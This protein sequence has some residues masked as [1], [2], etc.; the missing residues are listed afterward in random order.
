VYDYLQFG[1]PVEDS[2]A[3]RALAQISR[4]GAGDQPRRTGPAHASPG[5]RQI[6]VQKGVT[7]VV[8]P[9]TDMLS[10]GGGV[11]QDFTHMMIGLA[12]AMKIPARY[13]SGL[14]HPD[15]QRYRAFQ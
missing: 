7:T 15:E 10:K 4:P 11:C 3:L 2:P 13:V 1:G 14:V 5:G 12:R 8:S 6:Q 9:I